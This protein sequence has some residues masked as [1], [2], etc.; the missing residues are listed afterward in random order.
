[1]SWTQETFFI[2]WLH[3]I[4]HYLGIFQT[5]SIICNLYYIKHSI[6]YVIIYSISSE[7]NSY[8]HE[9]NLNPFE[10]VECYYQNRVLGFDENVYNWNN[11]GELRWE[12]VLC[13]LVSWTIVCLCLIRG[14]QWTGKVLYF[15]VFFPFVVL[16][17][18]LIFISTL[19]GSEL[20]FKMFITPE[21]ETLFNTQVCV[22]TGYGTKIVTF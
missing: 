5:G 20:G 22:F 19:P 21:M 12:L 14:V 16:F 17:L 6:N 1:M 7:N 8:C 13:L 4:P 10:R 9:K 18:L 11:F 2:L 3:L 15:T